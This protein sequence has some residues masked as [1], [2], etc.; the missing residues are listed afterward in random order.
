MLRSEK[1]YEL[2]EEVEKCENLERLEQ[3]V[4]EIE[5]FKIRKKERKVLPYQNM[6]IGERNSQKRKALR[7][8]KEKETPKGIF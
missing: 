8:R 4:L 6:E 5:N 7:A 2:Y 1:L 3:L